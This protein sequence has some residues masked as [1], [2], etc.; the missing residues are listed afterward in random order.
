MIR[1]AMVVTTLVGA[2]LSFTARPQSGQTLDCSGDPWF[3]PE[4]HVQLRTVIRVTDA[5]KAHV[6]K[7]GVEESYAGKFIGTKTMG[8]AAEVVPLRSAMMPW[9]PPVTVIF[10]PE[11]ASP[12]AVS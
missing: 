5:N 4:G 6:T 11:I 3:R 1:K 10:P 8:H 12:S 9:A 2:G 7:F